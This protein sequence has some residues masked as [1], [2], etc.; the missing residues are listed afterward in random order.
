VFESTDYLILICLASFIWW[1][2][3]SI[4]IMMLAS[5]RGYGV[6]RWFFAGIF[7]GPIFAILLLMAQPAERREG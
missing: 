4:A 7:F 5:K 1:V 2:A 3:A 6:G